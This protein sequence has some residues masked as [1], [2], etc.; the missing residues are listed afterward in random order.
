MQ[1]YDI[2]QDIF[3][4]PC[5]KSIMD[6]FNIKKATVLH[7]YKRR[8]QRWKI[9]DYDEK[10]NHYPNKEISSF[11]IDKKTDVLKEKS[12]NIQKNSKNQ[13]LLF[14]NR[15]NDNKIIQSEFY[16]P[17]KNEADSCYIKEHLEKKLNK[18]SNEELNSKSFNFT[19]NKKTP[20]IQITKMPLQTYIKPKNNYKNKFVVRSENININA[21]ISDNKKVHDI[22]NNQNFKNSRRMI[23][24]Y[25]S[26]NTTFI[27]N[28]KLLENSENKEGIKKSP[29][30]WSSNKNSFSS[31][32]KKKI[33]ITGDVTEYKCDIT[34]PSPQ[35]EKNQENSDSN[36]FT[37]DNSTNNSE[38]TDELLTGEFIM[39]V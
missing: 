13:L 7:T 34:I 18:R 21:K 9:S 3:L 27:S 31:P 2:V 17:G 35:I 29:S 8:I 22:Y 4:S 30:K 38:L 36:L 12:I 10:E 33:E 26:K 28:K 15:K 1:I 37:L 32:E 20:Y 24:N 23:K 6:V 14:S 5:R 39:I 16:S 19:T 11:V 25:K